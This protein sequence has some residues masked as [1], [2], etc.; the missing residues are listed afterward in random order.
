MAK[1]MVLSLCPRTEWPSHVYVG[2][3]RIP[4]PAQPNGYRVCGDV[5]FDEVSK[6]C[7]AIT[8]VPGG[9]GAMTMACLLQNTMKAYKSRQ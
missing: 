8:P 3:H 2:I 4:D 1:G 9:V 5:K 7:E 6:K